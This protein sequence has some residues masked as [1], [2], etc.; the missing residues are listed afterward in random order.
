MTRTRWI[1]IQTA[2]NLFP[3]RNLEAEK[4]E[5]CE[6]ANLGSLQVR[7]VGTFEYGNRRYV[8]FGRRAASQRDPVQDLVPGNINWSEGRLVHSGSFSYDEI[9]V[10]DDNN[11]KRFTRGERLAEEESSSQRSGGRPPSWDWDEIWTYV[12]LRIATDKRPRSL[13]QLVAE[14]AEFCERKYG[15]E[16]AESTLKGK[17]SKL[18]EQLK[19]NPPS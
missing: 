18:V 12:C 8:T 15:R 2:I 17:F 11:F 1:A 4:S 3:R 9:E 16:P 13:S 6:L 5:F 14:V 7:A 10:R 19:R